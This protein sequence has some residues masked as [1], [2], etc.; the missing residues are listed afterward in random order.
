[1]FLLILYSWWNVT[2]FWYSWSTYTPT[3]Q[4]KLKTTIVLLY[5]E[6]KSNKI[7]LIVNY[8]ILGVPRVLVL[9]VS[10]TLDIEYLVPLR[11]VNWETQNLFRWHFINSDLSFVPQE[12]VGRAC[13]FH[14][15]WNCSTYRMNTAT[16]CFLFTIDMT[17]YVK[18]AKQLNSDWEKIDT[19]EGH[20]YLWL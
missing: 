13:L 6:R 12:L 1:M 19:F 9:T 4:C 10:P 20:H 3:F 18:H 17:I 14:S 8:F 7:V 5:E 2:T 16:I 11:H 15:D